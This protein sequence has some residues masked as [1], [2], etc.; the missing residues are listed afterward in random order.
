MPAF[1]V[2]DGTGLTNATSY[3]AVAD[4]DDYLSIRPNIDSWED[5]DSAGKEDYLMWA[6]RLLDQRARFRGQKYDA[7]NALEWPRV[8]AVDKNGMVVPYDIVPKPIKDATV[9]IAFY[10]LVN[11]LDP[12]MPPGGGGTAGGAIKSIKADVIEIVYTEASAASAQ[13]I[14]FP[15]GIND[16]LA[17]LGTLAS[18]MGGK[19]FG[20]I[21]RS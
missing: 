16:I 3:V 10:L 21:L 4:A 15:L 13:T 2:E 14:Y 12:A 1:V 5:L 6:T 17:G 8:G 7:T 9:E 18:G 19:G 20:R 11:A